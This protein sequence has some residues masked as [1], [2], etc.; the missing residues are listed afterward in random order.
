M[1]LGKRKKKSIRETFQSREPYK[2]LTLLVAYTESSTIA[3][4]E[5]LVQTL[6]SS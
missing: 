1:H 6:S 3:H 4:E 2:V 5:F